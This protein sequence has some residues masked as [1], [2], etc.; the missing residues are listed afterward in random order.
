MSLFIFKP[1]TGQVGIFTSL[2]LPVIGTAL[3]GL[4][5]GKGA[6]RAGDVQADAANRALDLT[7]QD[8]APFRAA[9]EA[10]LPTLTDLAIQGPE[11]DLTRAEG[12]RTIQNT[13]AAGGRLRS[14][15]ALTELVRFNNML[16]E[17]A[18]NSRI[19]ALQGLATLG[20]NTAAR[21]ATTSANLI[22][23]AG[24]ATAAGIAGRSNAL[25][26]VFGQSAGFLFNFLNRPNL[27]DTPPF[28]PNS[29]NTL[30][31]DL[32]KSGP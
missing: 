7:R 32:I 21:Q 15:G 13:A 22:T 8:T 20:G 9:G 26:D 29:G 28:N 1:F 27:G 4:F 25:S 11:T 6:E 12:F 3:G 19:N 2:L 31:P 5:A 30:N 16:N 14:G 24:N 10:V 17:G 23:G 18:F